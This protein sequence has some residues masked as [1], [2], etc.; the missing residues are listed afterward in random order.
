MFQ[1]RPL[2]L[3]TQTEWSHYKQF[4][5]LCSV[6]SQ[7]LDPECGIFLHSLR[8]NF[9]PCLQGNCN[10]L[11]QFNCFE[12]VLKKKTHPSMCTVSTFLWGQDLNLIL[13]FI[14]LSVFY[15][16]LNINF[17]KAHC[18][19]FCFV[20]NRMNVTKWDKYLLRNST[21]GFLDYGCH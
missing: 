14:Q 16:T 12:L 15:F 2:P 20:F 17:R 7:A 21:K 3:A 13:T 8:H 19:L 5:C 18:L 4:L 6:P 1:C 10:W 9:L 11:I